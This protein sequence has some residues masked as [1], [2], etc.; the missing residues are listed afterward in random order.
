MLTWT[1]I[2]TRAVAFQK[3]WKDC[4]GD[5]RQKAQTFEK[6]FMYVFGVDWHDGLHEHPIISLDGVLNYID[7]LLPGKILIEMKS[8]GK[9]LDAAFYSSHAVCSSSQA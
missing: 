5:E 7:Y 6:D 1:E 2:E 8:R 4:T 9:S 3:R